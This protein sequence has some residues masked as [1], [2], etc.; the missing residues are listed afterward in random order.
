MVHQTQYRNNTVLQR[1][2]NDVQVLAFQSHTLPEA[3]T[4]RSTHQGELSSVL[5]YAHSHQTV[6]K[7]RGNVRVMDCTWLI[8]STRV[9]CL[10]PHYSSLGA[11]HTTN[12]I[13]AMSKEY[14]QCEI[15]SKGDKINVHINTQNSK[16]LFN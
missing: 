4:C 11:E 9:V 10:V 6:Y 5:V 7:S 16:T 15:R 3:I 1:Q 14:G 2:D 12:S 13:G 8:S